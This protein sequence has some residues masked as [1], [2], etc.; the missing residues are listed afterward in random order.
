MPD[1]RGVVRKHSH[2]FKK[3]GPTTPFAKVTGTKRPSTSFSFTVKSGVRDLTVMKTTQSGFV[4]F[5]KCKYTSLPSD[6][7]R[8]LGKSVSSCLLTPRL[9]I[10]ISRCVCLYAC[11]YISIY[12]GTA[13]LAEW[14]YDSSCWQDPSF[15]FKEIAANVQEVL[16]HTIVGPADTGVYSKSVQE[17]LYLMGEACLKDQPNITKVWFCLATVKRCIAVLI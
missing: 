10:Y 17:T 11:M 1:S 8:I 7:D 9:I 3:V 2:A 14:D 13:I 4:G 15:P 6:T 5:H 12:I 16:L